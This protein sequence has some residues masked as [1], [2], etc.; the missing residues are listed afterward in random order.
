[1]LNGTLDEKVFKNYII[2]DYLFLQNFRK[3][4]GILLAK[5]PDETAM[6]FIVNMINGVDEEIEYIHNIYCKKLGI[7]HEDILNSFPMP[8]T[9]FY[10]AYLIKTAALEPF[11]VGLIATLPCHWIYYRI[12]VDMQGMLTSKANKYQEWIDGYGGE[13]W[14]ES[15][16]KH[17]VDVIE[18]MLRSANNET[19]EKMKQAFSTAMKLEYLFWDN[20]YQGINWVD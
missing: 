20:I 5:T 8:C 16:T 2:Q 13:S 10:N 17:F 3:V 18:V 6:R 1:L 14:E 4:Y 11:E 7:S 12:G 9:E 19:G 15:E